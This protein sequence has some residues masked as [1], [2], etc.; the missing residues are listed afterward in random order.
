MTINAAE[1][2]LLA[3][4]KYRWGFVGGPGLKA[5]GAVK[6]G[7]ALEGAEREASLARGGD[8]MVAEFSG[9]RLTFADAGLRLLKDRPAFTLYLRAKADTLN[10]TLFIQQGADKEESGDFE[11]SAWPVPYLERQNLMFDGRVTGGLP[12][13]GRRSQISANVKG[14]SGWQDVVVIFKKGRGLELF[15]NGELRKSGPSERMS[16]WMIPE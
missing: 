4:A 12:V 2:N 15:V 3:T 8:G 1:T 5:S 16:P 7:V 9:G 13:A 10:G 6:T 14:D 11:L